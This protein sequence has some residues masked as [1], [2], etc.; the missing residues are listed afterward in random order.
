MK[1]GWGLY[2]YILGYALAAYGMAIPGLIYYFFYPWY[3][4]KLVT[5]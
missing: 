1:L 5:D 3:K 2:G 4:R